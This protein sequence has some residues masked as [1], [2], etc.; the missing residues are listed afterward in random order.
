MV[1]KIDREKCIGC[2][3]CISICPALAISIVNNKAIVDSE[4]CLDCEECLRE[5]PA[6]AIRMV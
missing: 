5:C 6:E 3:T 1:A 2:E 4:L